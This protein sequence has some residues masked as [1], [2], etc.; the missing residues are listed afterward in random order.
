MLTHQLLQAGGP[1]QVHMNVRESSGRYLN[2]LERSSRLS[3][4]LAPAAMLAAS[5]PFGDV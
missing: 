3:I 2:G 4:H 1:H 5:H